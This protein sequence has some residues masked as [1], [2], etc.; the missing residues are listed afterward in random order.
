MR[1][2]AAAPV[3]PVHK[4]GCVFPPYCFNISGGEFRGPG[5]YPVPAFDPTRNRLYV[6]YTD[7]I[8][9]RAQVLLTYASASD[10]THWSTPQ[11]VAPGAGDRINVEMSIE[12][13][14]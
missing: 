3:K 14:S 5:S 7:I 6:A 11:I 10:V 12:P 1:R 2:R 8:N 4:E 13:S 9:G